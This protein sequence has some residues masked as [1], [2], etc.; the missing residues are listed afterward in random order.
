MASG[1]QSADLIERPHISGPSGEDHANAFAL[2]TVCQRRKRAG[3]PE[4]RRP[5]SHRVDGDH[6]ILF[7]HAAGTQQRCGLAVV[8]G[9]RIASI[10]G[11][12]DV[13]VSQTVRDLTAGSGFTFDDLGEQELKGV[14]G[15]WRISRLVA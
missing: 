14:P 13:L 12:S 7:P 5:A 15:T 3:L 4:L 8:I 6:P 1:H 10:A 2:E 9:S 11:P